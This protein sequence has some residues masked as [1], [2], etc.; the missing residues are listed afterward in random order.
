MGIRKYFTEEERKAASK[1]SQK[2]WREEH[3]NYMSEWRKNHPENVKSNWNRW[4]NKIDWNDYMAKFMAKKRLT[5]IGRAEYLETNY[6][7][8][9][10]ESNRGESTI[11][12]EWIVENIFTQP[13][14]YCGETDWK[15][16]GCDRINNTL[17]HTPENVVPCCGK[18]NVKKGTIKYDEF[19]R[20]IGKIV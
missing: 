1:E 10:K 20:M 6:K 5:L 9:D 17:P 7:R 18:C 4:A 12:A 19:M 3:P 13:C 11:T 16:L 15:K 2:K 8:L 14:H